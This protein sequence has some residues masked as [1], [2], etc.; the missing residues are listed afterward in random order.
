MK[1]VLFAVLVLAL[2]LQC[3]KTE[4]PVENICLVNKTANDF[5]AYNFVD[6]TPAQGDVVR[7]ADLLHNGQECTN[8]KAANA[9]GSWTAVVESNDQ[10]ILATW[11]GLFNIATGQSGSYDITDAHKTSDYRRELVGPYSIKC[12][13]YEINLSSKDTLSRTSENL[14]TMVDSVPDVQYLRI[15][16]GTYLDTLIKYQNQ[17]YKFIAPA[18]I[19]LFAPGDSAISFQITQTT[20]PGIEKRCQASGRYK[21]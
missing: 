12:S 6:I 17:I 21:H 16:A 5:T 18:G 20:S 4:T 15:K 14:I 1:K 8:L 10:V 3:K 7:I 9:S 13:C 19:V 11:S 2:A